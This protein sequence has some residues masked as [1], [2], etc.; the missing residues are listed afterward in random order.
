MH[1]WFTN[2]EH[3]Q[4]LTLCVQ[5]NTEKT[6]NIRIQNTSQLTGTN[7]LTLNIL[8]NIIELEQMKEMSN[9]MTARSHALPKLHMNC[10]TK[11][12]PYIEPPQQHQNDYAHTCDHTT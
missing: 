1:I 9:E 4:A 10:P 11:T 7:V 2:Y 5:S 8:L 6:S 3:K 12:L